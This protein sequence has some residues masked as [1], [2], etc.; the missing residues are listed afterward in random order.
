MQLGLD[1]A[2]QRVALEQRH[3]VVPEAALG[4]RRERLEPVVETEAREAARPV[5]HDGIEGREQADPSGGV[6]ELRE[7]SAPVGEREGRARRRAIGALDEH[8]SKPPGEG[9]ARAPRAGL[10]DIDR[11]P[12]T[13]ELARREHRETL[14]RGGARPL[15]VLDRA[16]STDVVVR[17][18]NPLGQVFPAANKA[19]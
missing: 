11:A 5:A 1:A 6:A 17:G 3:H 9:L 4:S 19:D 7:T 14:A 16:R 15:A 18:E 12:V 8:R 13:R 2:D 10:G